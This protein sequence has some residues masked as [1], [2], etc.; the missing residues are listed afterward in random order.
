LFGQAD[1]MYA[2]RLKN[3][4]DTFRRIVAGETF[5]PSG[6]SGSGIAALN[7]GITS[8]NATSSAF[9]ASGFG[10]TG[11]GNPGPFSAFSAKP[12]AF[13]A[14]STPVS[15]FG[16]SGAGVASQGAG[17]PTPSSAT[18]GGFGVSNS[19]TLGQPASAAPTPAFGA[20]SQPA[21]APAFGSTTFG[22][23]SFGA[24]P[25][26]APTFGQSAF[27]QP[28]PQSAFGQS[29]FGQFASASAAMAPPNPV[30]QTTSSAVLSQQVAPS[31]AFPPSNQLTSAFGSTAPVTSA[32]GTAARPP[33][34]GQPLTVNTGGQSGAQGFNGALP[35][36]SAGVSAP[37]APDPYAHLLPPNYIQT[38]P[39]S[40][41]AAF[42]REEDFEWGNIP[43]WIPPTEM[44]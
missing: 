44:R 12:V 20:F 42:A 32:F 24:A 14:S 31:T 28:K 18:F 2:D 27:G 40:I 30:S 11:G 7:T 17:F 9:G 22:Q 1:E 10:T 35:T 29:G 36:L 3:V 13:G 43:E 5:S 6:P 41:K 15:A 37:A 26:S 19:T 8:S 16:T 34:F 39:E 4:Q 33:A 21:K 38:L 23:S 25:A